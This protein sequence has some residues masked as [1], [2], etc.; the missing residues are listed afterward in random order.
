MKRRCSLALLMLV[1]M[2]L[3]RAAEARA[4]NFSAFPK[5]PHAVEDACW[6][7]DR[8]YFLTTQG[9]FGAAMGNEKWEITPITLQGPQ[10]TLWSIACGDLLPSPGSELVVSRVRNGVWRSF[11]LTS[12][13]GQWKIARDELP[14]A[15]RRVTWKGQE[16]WVGDARFPQDTARGEFFQVEASG[17]NLKLGA[18]IRL[19]HGSVLY[20]WVQLPS[21]DV[22]VLR[23]R[24]VE[25]FSNGPRWRLKGRS[26]GGGETTHCAES[27]ATVFSS[28]GTVV[29]RQLAPA[30]WNDILIVPHNQL[31]TDQVLGRVPM[32]EHGALEWMTWDAALEGYQVADH[33]G[34]FPGELASYF[35]DKNPR[36]G[37]MTLF[38]VVQVRSAADAVGGLT[39]YSL[40]V[41][42]SLDA[43]QKSVSK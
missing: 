25:F 39:H 41:P 27:Q 18:R 37:L 4:L 22:A 24:H 28:V 26:P 16:I 30:F 15:L 12:A 6:I 11:V 19:P 8:L 20:N 36:D 14:Y 13:D 7:G 17:D 29:C 10:E 21:G 23:D 43:Q 35:I 1:V 9:V 34:P 33:L 32:I 42:V 38:L 2:P 3:S 40:L 5:L 31:I